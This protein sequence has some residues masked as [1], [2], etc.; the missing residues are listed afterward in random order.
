MAE[1]K[2]SFEDELNELEKT[3]NILEN[4]DCSLD[5]AIA[6]FEKGIKLSSDCRK[7][8]EKARQKIVTLTDAEN[9]AADD[10]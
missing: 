10:D 1:K 2:I 6:L 8:L 5:E 9:G 7:T 3:V 4:G